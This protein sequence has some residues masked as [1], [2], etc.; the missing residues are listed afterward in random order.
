MVTLKRFSKWRVDSNQ[1]DN[2]QG[3]VYLVSR[4][5]LDLKKRKLI[6]KTKIKNGLVFVKVNEG[7][8]F[9]HFKSSDDLK[10]AVEKK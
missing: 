3:A 6:Q 7:D 4:C 9:V 8:K 5:A 10:A 2:N 1:G